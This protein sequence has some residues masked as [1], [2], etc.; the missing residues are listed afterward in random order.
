MVH[1]SYLSNVLDP[2]KREGVISDLVVCM[3]QEQSKG[4]RFQAV[5]FTGISGALVAPVVADRVRVG[6]I[7]VRKYEKS[8]SY[9][10]VE[11]LGEP[12][13]QH[14]VIVDDCI[15]S[16]V[17]ISNILNS[18]SKTKGFE[19]CICRGIFLYNQS[20]YGDRQGEVS[21]R[22]VVPMYYTLR[23]QNETVL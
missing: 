23:C 1:A 14:Y 6:L 11:G 4:L 17:T 21:P 2:S 3:L 7:A 16:G 5:A 10:Q 20:C 18:I 19:S 15:C 13:V 12:T 9:L 22:F 8:H